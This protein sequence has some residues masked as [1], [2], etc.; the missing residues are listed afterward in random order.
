LAL[1]PGT[2]LGVYEITEQIGEGGMG[3]VYRATDTKLKRQVAIK[4][5][6]PSLAADHDRL[7]RFQREAEVLAS[8][9]HA[10]IAGIY[11]LEESGGITALVMELVEGDDLSQRIARGAIPLDEALPIAKQIAEALEAAHE[12]GIIHRDLKPA[13]IKV[14][15]DGTVK[16]LD[17]GLAKTVEPAAM[18]SPGLSQ[19]P[20]IMT[21]AMT[22]MGVILGTVAYMAPEQAEGKDVGKRADVWAFGVLLY[23]LVTGRRPFHAD[24]VQATLAAV[25]TQEP[26]WNKVPERLQRLLRACLKKDPRQRLSSIGDWRLLLEDGE[27]R[28][29][30]PAAGTKLAWAAAVLGV[31]IGTFGLFR[32]E[33][34]VIEGP[35]VRFEVPV[36]GGVGTEA[37]FALS[38]DGH[39]LAIAAPEEGQFRLS[40]RPLDAREAR[41]LPSTEGARYPFWK[42]DGSAIGFF[43]DGKLKA[44]P[45]GGGPPVLITN[46]DPVVLGAAWSQHGT[47]VFSQGRDLYTVNEKG[48][49]PA[50]LY[51]GPGIPFEPVFLPDGRRFLFQE[52]G[53]FVGSLDGS[54][55]I[56]IQNGGRA[57]YS[58]GYLLFRRQGR[59]VAQS[60]DTDTLNL[61]GAEIAVTSDNVARAAQSESFSVAGGVLAYQ[62]PALEQLA[63]KDRSGTATDLVA[64]P[65]QWRY[66]RL[67]PDQSRI[68]WDFLP[69]GG[70]AVFDVQRGTRER[71]TTGDGDLE[72]SAPV[73]SPDGTQIALLKKH[74][75]RHN[76]YVTSAPNQERLLADV[77][78]D[79]GYVVDWSPDGTNVLY[80]GDEDLWIVPVDG[81]TKP[82]TYAQS[83][84]DERDGAFSP[85][86]RWMAYTSSESGRYEVYLQSFPQEGGTR[87]TVSSQGGFGP[88]WRRD[89]K[90]LFF[91][92]GD[93][94]LT[95]VPVTIRGSKV[96][97]G[98][99]QS[100]FP[101]TVSERHRGYHPSL[102]GQR[103]LVAMPESAGE[104]AITVLL[105]W[106]RIVEK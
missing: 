7:A 24:S 36:P 71:L 17:F 87:Y 82:Y 94:R 72:P 12:R 49:A 61:S 63:W 76:P 51:G 43:A 6:P 52:D 37:H 46:V 30:A 34:P 65:Q 101:V 67:S 13:N 100:L 26:D 56:K 55:L 40:V 102:D 33:K 91:V 4:T 96:E 44:V 19:S 64:G 104:A 54:P 84:S 74:N 39:H 103:F 73:F 29:V 68:A 50:R 47:I 32:P 48:G 31:G 15:A 62:E 57:D 11:G 88:A 5:L 85:D 9:N 27:S 80:W 45:L 22:Q 106:R 92:A 42:P 83:V 18:M 105:N 14:R 69:L 20:T 8:L 97:L 28:S 86:G 75:G 90:E 93:G 53:L 59:L 78:T 23:E 66:F 70:V 98:R 21:P 1:T 77:G 58:D 38:P 2:R 35:V 25:L 3:Q 41:L 60:F 89:G 79:A 95:A 99:A 81:K 16:V 10:N